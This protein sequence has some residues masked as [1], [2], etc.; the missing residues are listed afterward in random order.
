MVDFP[1]EGLD[2]TPYILDKRKVDQCPPVYD[3]YAVSNHSGSLHGGHY[4][5]HVL[6]PFDKKW[7][8][9]DD[10]HLDQ[11]RHPQEEVVSSHAYVLFYRRRDVVTKPFTDPTVVLPFSSS[12]S[13]S[14]EAVDMN[15][16]EE[17]EKKTVVEEDEDEDPH[18]PF[19]PLPTT[20]M[21]DEDFTVVGGDSP[22]VPS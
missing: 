6:N 1:L 15:H 5:A 22:P 2:L 12:S 4:T 21:E 11:V 19:K 9:C 14:M 20:P 18:A 3:L 13:V 8:N 17:E 7:Y 10:S 16:D